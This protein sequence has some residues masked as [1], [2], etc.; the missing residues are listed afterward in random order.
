[1]LIGNKQILERINPEDYISG[2]L[3][4]PSLKDILEELKKPGADPRA[5][6]KPFNFDPTVKTI[7]DLKPGMKL[8]GIVNNITNF[9]CFVD[10]GIKESGLIHI[11]KL[12]NE[13]ISDVNTVVKLNQELEVT[14]LS[15]D[16]EK[17]RVQLSLVD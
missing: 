11:S 13:F 16:E 2:D 14:V 12:A 15:V 10:I 8:P 4:L 17:K 5:K 7:A 3:G 6:K 9:G 1:A